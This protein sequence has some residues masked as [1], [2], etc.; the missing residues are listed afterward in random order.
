MKSI[1]WKIVLLCVIVI[2][3]PVLLLNYYTVSV[4]NR[5]TTRDLEEHMIHSAFMVSEQ[6]KSLLDESGCIDE[7]RRTNLTQ[8]VNAFSREI[9]ARIQV[10]SPAGLVLCDSSTNAA[11]NVDVLML[12][13]VVSALAGKYR[14]RSALTEDRQYMYYFIAYPVMKEG[15]VCGV[16]HVSRHTSNIVRT[17][18]RMIKVQRITTAAAIMIGILLATVL[19]YSITSRL[20]RL[21][22]ATMAFA[23]GDAPF[24]VSVRGG[25]E[26]ADLARAIS[27]MATEIKR[28][29]Q[30]NREFIS[31]VMHELKMPITAIK[32]AAELLEQ[33]AFNKDEARVKFLGN[34]R[35]EVDRLARMVWELNEL[36]KLDIEIP[37]AQKEKVD[38]GMCVKEIVERFEPTLDVQHARICVT[39]PERPIHARVIPGRIEQV[40]GNLIDNAVRYT[41]SSGRIEIEVNTESDNTITTSV[42]DT[43]CGISASNLG[44]VFDRFFTTEPKD[45]P[46]DYG[47]G[48]GLA[49]ARSIVESHQGRIWVESTPGQGT[50]FFF[51]LPT[52]E[53]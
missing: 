17:I 8:T 16:V 35:F 4:F 2:V 6:Y 28:T 47:S 30:Y 36:T 48:L 51:S 40:L 37:R 33:G 11:E 13:E 12:P 53:A 50:T 49:I 18:N 9:Q 23:S 26:V 27:L 20:R 7:F 38:Y 25:D 31:T 29:N 42:H 24:A 19:A 15:H 10:L 44:K 32:G 3:V 22:T 1:R 46:K 45:K 39:V 41:P 5:F 21:T 34:I 52:A 43:G 14:A